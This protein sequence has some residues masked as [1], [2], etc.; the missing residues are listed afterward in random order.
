VSAHISSEEEIELLEA[1]IEQRKDGVL[2]KTNIHV[3]LEIFFMNRKPYYP[4]N[5]LRN[6]AIDNVAGDY[7]LNLDVDLVIPSDNS[8]PT[9]RSLLEE[10]K[11]EDV[12][13]H[14][15]TTTTSTTL[16]EYLQRRNVLVLPAFEVFSK[17][18]MSRSFKKMVP[19]SREDLLEMIEGTHPYAKAQMFHQSD[20][21]KC[22]Q[23]T[24][25]TRWLG[26]DDVAQ[27]KKTNQD[28]K[29]TNGD[30]DAL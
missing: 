24:T 20:Q 29:K 27:T 12:S 9:I 16:R 23:A 11:T 17:N 5:M 26:G 14:T 18:D 19:K 2:A 28:G 25:F 10:S 15:T 8:Y 21:K 30:D 1:F 22:Q 4:H 6:L 7:L 13:S 3:V